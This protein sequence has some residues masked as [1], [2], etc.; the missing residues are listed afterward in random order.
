FWSYQIST[1]VSQTVEVQPGEEVTL[2]C[3]NLS[4]YSG[5]TFWFRLINRTD[6]SCIAVMF[7][8]TKSVSHCDGF[9]SESFE[10]SSNISTVFL[11]I[12]QVAVSDSG[13]YFCG[14]YTSGRPLFNISGDKM[15]V[16]CAIFATLTVFLILIIAGLLVKIKKHQKVHVMNFCTLQNLGS[17]DV[18]Y[19]TPEPNVVYAATR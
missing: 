2:Q 10:M 14:F 4:S 12:K 3:T 15:E 17:D 13:L 16:M 6:A 1:S 9:Q 7:E 5:V 18:N 11:K 19:A 8:S